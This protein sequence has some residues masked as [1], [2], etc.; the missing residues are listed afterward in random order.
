MSKVLRTASWHFQ[1]DEGSK[2]GSSIVLLQFAA[3]SSYNNQVVFSA[4]AVPAG[5]QDV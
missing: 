2:D 5:Q 4:P 3:A 1:S